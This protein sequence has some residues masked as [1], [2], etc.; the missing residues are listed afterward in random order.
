MIKTI[1]FATIIYIFWTVV[2]FKYIFVI[3][4]QEIKLLNFKVR[5]FESVK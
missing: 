3:S 5:P 4:E 2:S 1:N